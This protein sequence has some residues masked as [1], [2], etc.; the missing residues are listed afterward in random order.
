MEV[1]F[2][3]GSPH[4]HPAG[5]EQRQQPVAEGGEFLVLGSVAF[6][7]NHAAANMET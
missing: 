5:H 7:R 2:C 1:F 4:S 3:P 6:E